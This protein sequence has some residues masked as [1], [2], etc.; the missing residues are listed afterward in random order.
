MIKRLNRLAGIHPAAIG[1][2]LKTVADAADFDPAPGLTKVPFSVLISRFAPKA[3]PHSQNRTGPAIGSAASDFL[4]AH[5]S[6]LNVRRESG[7]TTNVM[8]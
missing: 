1:A 2:G 6:S 7:F 5:F 8:P 3:L 4:D